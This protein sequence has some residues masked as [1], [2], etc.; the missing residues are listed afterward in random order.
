MRKLWKNVYCTS[1]LMALI[2]IGLMITAASTDWGTPAGVMLLPGAFIAALIFPD[3]IES[4]AGIAF[5]ILAA[6]FDIILLALLLIVVRRL[7]RRMPSK[8]S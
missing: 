6:V 7:F 1:F 3:G 8:S 4:D 2:L 5:I